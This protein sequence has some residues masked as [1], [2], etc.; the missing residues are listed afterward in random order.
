VIPISAG[1]EKAE[2]IARERRGFYIEWHVEE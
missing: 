2:E 1:D